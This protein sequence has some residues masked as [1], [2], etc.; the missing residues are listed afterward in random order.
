M[1][2]NVRRTLFLLVATAANM[3]L[4][5]IIIVVIFIALNALFMAIGLKNAGTAIIIVSFLAGIVL[6]GFAYSK[7]LKALQKRPELVERFG[8]LK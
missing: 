1:T 4:T 7:V 3:L 5:V 6:S 8:L 2:K